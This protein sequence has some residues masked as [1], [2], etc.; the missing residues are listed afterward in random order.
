MEKNIRF[1]IS[2]L[3]GVTIEVWR[4]G[5]LA[6]CHEQNSQI[7]LKRI[8]RK[9]NENLK[10]LGVEIVDFTGQMY[11]PG[12][13]V[14]VSEILGSKHLDTDLITIHE[15]ISPTILHKRKLIHTGSV[16]LKIINSPA[17]DKNGV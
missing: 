9:L 10:S 13:S 7:G 11:D 14:H 5:Q 3:I 6:N 15:T 2:D 4:L 16:I 17:S 12:I 8:S 1:K